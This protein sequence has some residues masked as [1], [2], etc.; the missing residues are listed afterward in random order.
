MGAKVFNSHPN[1]F[2]NETFRSVSLIRNLIHQTIK[3]FQ[4]GYQKEEEAL[5]M[6]LSR[7]RSPSPKYAEL[8]YFTLLCFAED[9]KKMYIVL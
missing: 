5:T 1:R 2:F 6:T 9:G 3:L 7:R 4:N 8:S